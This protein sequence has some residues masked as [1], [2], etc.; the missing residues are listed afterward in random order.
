[1]SMCGGGVCGIIRDYRGGSER[2][3]NTDLTL[4]PE[5]SGPMDRASMWQVGDSNPSTSASKA[6][7]L[8][9]YN[10]NAGHRVSSCS[11]NTCLMKEFI[12]L[13]LSGKFSPSIST[14]AHPSRPISNAA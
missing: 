4:T 1:M 10:I 11:I 9:H 7:A 5:G 2:A 12:L 14:L 6:H 8:N 13:P 3:K